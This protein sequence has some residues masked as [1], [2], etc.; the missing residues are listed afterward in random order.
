MYFIMRNKL[1]FLL[2]ICLLL[3]F[4][5]SAQVNDAGLWASVSIEK[6]INKSFSVNLS[7]ELRFFENMT[8]LGSF[9]TEVSLDYKL[10]KTFGFSAGYRFTNKRNVDDSYSKRHRYLL[11]ATIKRKFNQLN[12]GLRLRYQS[13][14]ADYYSDADGQIPANYFRTKLS[15]KYDL[16]KKYTPFISGETFVHT[17][18][19]DGI[20]LDNYR[21]EGGLEYEFS[22]VSSVQ[23]SY[24][25][26]REVQ[27]NDPWTLYVI[28][29]SW[30]YVLK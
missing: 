5:L 1:N 4:V 11:N 14:Y 9:F 21:L 18:R 29:V 12:A 26:N 19:P 3:P 10:N 30:S 22:K 25:Y 16:N 6:K 15:F 13:Q 20:L 23:I 8:E 27:V 24:I 17:N 2:A 28:G 7:E